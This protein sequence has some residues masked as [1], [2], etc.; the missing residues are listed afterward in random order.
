MDN[1]LIQDV[2][3]VYLKDLSTSTQ[4][5]FGLTTKNEVTQKVKQDFLKGGIGN[6]TVGVVQSEKEITFKVTTLLHNDNLY[7]IQSGTDFATVSAKTIYSE[8]VISAVAGKVTPTLKVGNTTV[9]PTVGSVVVMDGKG[10]QIA[11]TWTSPD[12]TATTPADIAVGSAY[13]VFYQITNATA[14]VLTLDSKKFPKNYYVELHTIAYDVDKNTVV[15]DIYW[16]F[17]KALP[18]GGLQAQY[19]A[20]KGNGD[21]VEF[22]AQLLAGNSSYGNYVVMPRS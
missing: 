11:G 1:I 2:C 16:Q 6:G 9:T 17:N 14:Q 12:F 15:A 18:N 8:S 21:D 22:T 3:E 4:Y 5:F 20:G 13:T 10:K 7:A 19:E